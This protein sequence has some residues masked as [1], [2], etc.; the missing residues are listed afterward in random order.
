M[1]HSGRDKRI[2][3]TVAERFHAGPPE[4]RR[5]EGNAAAQAELPLC[6]CV[7]RGRSWAFM[8]LQ[9]QSTA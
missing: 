2:P 8:P 4:R 3:P 1:A 9:L 5:V 7:Q 6:N